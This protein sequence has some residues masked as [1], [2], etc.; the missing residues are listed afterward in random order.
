VSL[1]FWLSDPFLSQQI[2]R[3]NPLSSSGGFRAFPPI[4]SQQQVDANPHKAQT[5]FPNFCNPR[6]SALF[7]SEVSPRSTFTISLYNPI[8]PQG[9][10]AVPSLKNFYSGVFHVFRIPFFRISTQLRSI[11][12]AGTSSFAGMFFCSGSTP[13]PFFSLLLPFFLLDIFPLSSNSGTPR[14]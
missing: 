2:P 4:P 7:S 6:G 5:S 10:A 8:P 1:L 11:A 13:P 3:P 9:R 14:Q 12:D